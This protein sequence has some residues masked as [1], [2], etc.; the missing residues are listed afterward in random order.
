MKMITYKWNSSWGVVNWCQNS[1]L[2]VWDPELCNCIIFNFALELFLRNWGKTFMSETWRAVPW[3]YVESMT[4]GT[5][6]A[7]DR[8]PIWENHCILNC[9]QVSFVKHSRR[10]Y[11]LDAWQM[12]KY[13][14]FSQWTLLALHQSKGSCSHSPCKSSL[15]FWW[16]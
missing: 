12:A 8:W 13:L 10:L 7:C 1:H 14:V 4:V 15:S 9:F 2:W 5:Q 16:K 11:F 6:V 3:V